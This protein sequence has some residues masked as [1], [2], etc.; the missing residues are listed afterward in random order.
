[1][2]KALILTICMGLTLAGIAVAQAPSFTDMQATGELQEHV[3]AR[4]NTVVNKNQAN[5]TFYFD[6][7]SFEAAAPDLP[8]ET[9][10]GGVVPP[11]QLIGCGSPL[12][13][14]ISNPCFPAGTLLPGFEFHASSDTNVVTLGAGVVPPLPALSGAAVAADIFNDFSYLSFTDPDVY[15]VGFGIYDFFGSPTI[16]IDVSSANGLEGQAMALSGGFFGVVSDTPITNIQ[17]GAT[18]NVSV[19]DNLCFGN[20]VLDTDGD[21]V[22]DDEDACSESDLGATVVIDGCDSGVSNALAAD[23]CTISDLIGECAEGTSNHGQ[24]VRCVAHLTNDLKKAGEISG[25]DKGA[26]NSCAGQADIP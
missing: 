14:A 24:F 13:A 15:A 12:S 3:D 5:L 26:I 23:G 9:F 11:G 1:M 20:P 8:K 22:A 2:K 6:Q 25:A 19:L 7:A 4:I 16:T 18:T 10:E 21:G 17:L